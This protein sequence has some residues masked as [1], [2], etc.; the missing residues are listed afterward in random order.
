MTRKT[1][2]STLSRAAILHI[3]VPILAALTAYGCGSSSTINGTGGSS[4]TAGTPGTTGAGGGA[5]IISGTGGTPGGGDAG[6]PR[7]AGRPPRDAGVGGAVDA[8]FNMCTPNTPCTTG[9]TCELPCNLGGVAGTRACTCNNNGSLA[10][11]QNNNA[12]CVR[13]D[14]GAPPPR[15]D[16]GAPPPRPDAGPMIDA[17]PICAGGANGPRAGR[18]CVLGTDTPCSRNGGA[19][20]TQ[21]CTC[22]AAPPR[23][24]GATDAATTADAGPPAGVWTCI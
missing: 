10:C 9:F 11:A 16:A 4:G 15:L 18:P 14:A 5:V 8:G 17:G 22:G 24:A 2:L 3:V 6:A 7:D 13:P 12:G 21:T 23:D 19:G 20:V 1:C